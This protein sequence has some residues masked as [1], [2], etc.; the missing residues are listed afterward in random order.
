MAW[1]C[2]RQVDF[3]NAP[4][5][6]SVVSDSFTFQ[7]GAI[8]LIVIAYVGKHR[9]A[10]QQ[11]ENKR[12]AKLVQIALDTLRNQELAHYTDPIAAPQPYLSS[13]Q[14]RDLI[15][16]DEHSIPVRRRLWEK[17]GRV[18]EGNANVRTNLEEVRGGDEMRVWRWVGG[19]GLRKWVQT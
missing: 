9:R 17:V 4:R 8:V 13:V 6:K 19:S 16:Q 7:K 12:V 5:G 10:R 15:L 2:D 14:L 3:V 1:N 11:I 18:V